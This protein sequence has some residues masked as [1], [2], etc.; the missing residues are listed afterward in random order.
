MRNRRSLAARMSWGLAFQ[1]LAGL[2]AV[3]LAVY[4]LTSHN[5]SAR[6]VETLTQKQALI[7]HVLTEA[8]ASG[9]LV[10]LKHRLDD[11]LLGHKELVLKVVAGSGDTLYQSSFTRSENLR[12]GSQFEI[13]L[14][15]PSADSPQQASVMTATLKLDPWAD[16]LLLQQL[17]ITLFIAST[18]GA[19]LVSLAGFWLVRRGLKP[20]GGLVAQTRQLAVTNLSQRLDG[21]AQPDELRPLVDQ[22]NEVLHRLQLAYEQVEAFN[23][24]VAHELCN[25]LTT[26]IT[27]TELAFRKTRSTEDLMEVLGSNLEDLRRLSGI[28]HDM[29]FLSRADRGAKARRTDPI[30]LASLAT[31]VIDYHDAALEEAHLEVEVIGDARLEV[32]AALVRRA[33]S[34]LIGNATRYASPGSA[35]RVEISERPDGEVFVGVTNEGQTVPP[36]QLP[37]LFDRFFRGESSRSESASHHGLGLAIVAAVAR[38]HGGMG[39]ATSAEGV[40]TIGMTLRGSHQPNAV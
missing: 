27:S 36:D 2:G 9:D 35:I 21:S 29:L 38:M 4:A 32:D 15:P 16:Q 24:D 30:S 31:D 10:G 19:L 22:F 5:L 1:A 20:V 13:A 3:A 11:F 40:T 18:A 39:V 23:A 7:Q 12:L 25:P 17:A 34:N 33:L 37:R 8:A 26:L 6:R 14:A 28:V